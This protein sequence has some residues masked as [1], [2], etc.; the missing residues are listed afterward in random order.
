MKIRMNKQ[1]PI[2][3]I[4]KIDNA[5]VVMEGDAPYKFREDASIENKF[6]NI[7]EAE[8][9]MKAIFTQREIS[10][11][12]E[13]IFGEEMKNKQEPI[14]WAVMQPDSYSVFTSYDKAVVHRENCAGGDIVSLYSSSSL[15]DDECNAI[16]Q[17]L[18]MDV[19]QREIER[20]DYI[21]LQE[22]ILRSLVKRAKYKNEY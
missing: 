9:M 12:V 7:E 16:M 11:D 14:A 1:E 21:A 18:D 22:S 20:D 10:A 15:T 3:S 8:S 5:F 4:K 2:I 19:V 17:I 6:K 13:K